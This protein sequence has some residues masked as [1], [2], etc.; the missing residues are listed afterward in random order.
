MIAPVNLNYSYFDT[1]IVFPI[2]G[3]EMG[4]LKTF[5]KK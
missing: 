5:S 2:M 4:Y 1:K 3:V